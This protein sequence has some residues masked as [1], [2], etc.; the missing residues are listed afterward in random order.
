[1]WVFLENIEIQ[2]FSVVQQNLYDL[3]W[4]SNPSSTPSQPHRQHSFVVYFDQL[5]GAGNT[6]FQPFS[7]LNQL[8]V[9][10]ASV[11]FLKQQTH[12]PTS[13]NPAHWTQTSKVIFAS[14]TLIM[15]LKFC[16]KKLAL[17][18][19]HGQFFAVLIVKLQVMTRIGLVKQFGFFFSSSSQCDQMWRFVAIL[20]IFGMLLGFIFP[21]INKNWT[22]DVDILAFEKFI[23]FLWQQIWRFSPKCWLFFGLNSWSHYF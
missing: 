7:N 8:T 3:E 15:P 6:F 11:Y 22:F 16:Y 5:S 21:K 20:A 19:R 1:M 9:C 23:Y 13:P 18:I 12:T 17:K 14:L 4:L 10:G 2:S